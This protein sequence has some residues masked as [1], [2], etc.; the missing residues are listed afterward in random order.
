MKDVQE[1]VKTLRE[2][3]GYKH[4]LFLTSYC[5]NSSLVPGLEGCGE[6]GT[7][8]TDSI[9]THDLQIN[10]SAVTAMQLEQLQD[11]AR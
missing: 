5:D 8:T 11:H 4:L 6:D 1:H 7:V 9:F 10:W 3:M 2:S